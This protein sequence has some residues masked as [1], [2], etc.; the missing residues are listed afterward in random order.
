MVIHNNTVLVI[1]SKLRGSVD[2]PKGTV[3]NKDSLEDTALREVLEETGYTCEIKYD[4]GSVTYDFSDG[5]NKTFRKTVSYFLMTVASQDDPI[6]NLQAG[7]DFENE[8]LS[9]EDALQ[10]LT[11]SEARNMVEKA[12]SL[13]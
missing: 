3:E 12:F 5:P 4:L 2:L 13:L 6:K 9:K 7:E 10:R 1:T 8:W 11:F